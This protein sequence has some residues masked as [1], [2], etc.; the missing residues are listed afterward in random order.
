MQTWI[1][2]IV[3]GLMCIATVLNVIGC[4]KARRIRLNLRDSLREVNNQLQQFP[5]AAAN[6]EIYYV[7][8]VRSLFLMDH[9]YPSDQFEFTKKA[10]WAKQYTDLSLAIDI[11][12][13]CNGKVIA[14]G[15]INPVEKANK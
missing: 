5:I 3:F 7:I 1:Y 8:K 12:N 2:W 13:D 11:A 6:D 14:Y 4:F 15:P 10:A 9:H